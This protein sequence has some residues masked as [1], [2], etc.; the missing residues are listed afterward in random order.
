MSPEKPSYNLAARIGRLSASHPKT[1]RQ[2]A[3]VV[4]QLGSGGTPARRR[5]LALVVLVAVPPSARHAGRKP[6]R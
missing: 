1:E 5:W 6:R 3:E 4:A 2:S